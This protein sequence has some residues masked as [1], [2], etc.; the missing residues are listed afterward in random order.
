MLSNKLGR[1]A[2]AV[3]CFV[4]LIAA[5]PKDIPKMGATPVADAAMQ[6]DGET[7]RAL[8]KQGVDVNAAQGDGMTA[9]HWA[10]VKADVEMAEMLLY[11]GANV[12]AATRL[13]RFTPLFLAAKTGD[14]AVVE[15]LVNASADVNIATTMGA[16]P[17][18]VA[19]ASGNPD[20]VSILLEHGAE[21]NAVEPA[22]GQA[23]L[24]FAAAYNRGDVI[25]ALVENGADITMAT[26]IVETAAIEKK[27]SEADRERRKEREAAAKA[28]AA[29]EAKAKGLEPPQGVEET[30]P[31]KDEGKSVLAKVFGWVPGV[32][33]D[34][35]K[36]EQRRRFRRSPFGQLVGNQGG[37]TALLLASRQGNRE[38]VDALVAA[39]SDVNVVSGGDHTSPL[40]IATINGHFDL[41][42]SLLDQ[43]ADP[44]LASEA[45]ATA[46]YGAINLQW[47]PKALYPQ[48]Q[49]Y[50]QQ[51]V[52]Y[53]EL[54]ELLLEAGVDPNVRL[55]K[56]LWYSGYNFDLS[57]VNEN[58]A[59]AFWRAAYG[60]DI[61]AMKLLIAYGA[62]P[63][64]PT[65]KPEVDPSD[66]IGPQEEKEDVSGLPP[67]PPG[68]NAVS[69]LLA[70]AGVGYGRGFA[71]NSHRHHPAGSMAALRYL[72]EELGADVNA[73][74]HDAYNALH[75]AASRGDAEMVQYLY[76]K[77]CDIT[78]I[79]RRGQSTAD[80][81]NGPVQR[82]QPFPEA[83]ALLEQLGSVNNHNCVGC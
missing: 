26:K 60:T 32:G 2:S 35:K 8:L 40:L 4:A 49:A 69:P 55:K 10:G 52:S 47:S 73:Q 76:D 3:L 58:G 81:A 19:A 65:L 37:M 20:T 57:G 6:G 44:N 7:V 63:N 70:A 78:A 68:G 50:R 36:P 30:A 31:P 59:T 41:A 29:A 61:D 22:R 48:P 1:S 77:G 12:K 64:L 14:A 28:A 46:L 34:E 79:S 56:K 38:A 5:A 67:V 23:A 42:K 43:G 18:M 74:D 21:V 51:E 53:L 39:G 11:A 75:H 83:L 54:M 15:T 25:D 45:G 72:V 33:G 62:D 82:V 9:L 80:M 17:L 24:M 13:G 66:G 71:A 27:W 16:T